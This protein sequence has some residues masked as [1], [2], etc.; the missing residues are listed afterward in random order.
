[1]DFSPEP[2]TL[3]RELLF[4]I[5]SRLPPKILCQLR[6]VCAKWLHLLT[7]DPEF[8]ALYHQKHNLNP[9]LL[10]TDI[11]TAGASSINLSCYYYV[12]GA[13]QSH[14]A[15]GFGG[16]L[17]SILTCRGIAC[18]IRT[19]KIILY[20]P[21]IYRSATVRCCSDSGSTIS[22]AFGY[23]PLSRAFKIV[24]FYE[25]ER[26]DR[27]HYCPVKDVI[28]E[29]QVQPSAKIWSSSR[30]S[31]A[32]WRSLG[33]CQF[34]FDIL[35]R[36]PSVSVDRYV[37]WLIGERRFNPDCIRILSF[38]LEMESFGIV[39]FPRFYSNRSVECVGLL[40]MGERLCL[41]D[42]LPWESTMD[43]WMLQ[44]GGGN[45]WRKE[46]SINLA[47]IDLHDFRIIGHVACREGDEGEILIK[48]G[49]LG[50]VFYVVRKCSFRR[51]KIAMEDG[52]DLQLI[53]KRKAGSTAEDEAL[54]AI[55]GKE[56]AGGGDREEWSQGAIP[57]VDLSTPSSWVELPGFFTETGPSIIKLWE[58]PA[59]SYR[60]GRPI[61]S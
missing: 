60:M 61:Q 3:P 51:L 10:F 6:C 43:I 31:R 46:H 37:Y 56:K 5:F 28:C 9:L 40:E 7:S 44:D 59:H 11:T 18:L 17:I 13:L 53:L 39:C 15:A 19:S 35:S 29:V 20:D 55:H 26:F 54:G 47:G 42:R 30:C 49:A 14:F 24:R 41:T 27:H 25:T 38:D 2:N 45:Q 22:F 50:Y 23:A 33:I 1:M 34:D 4:D 12:D 8:V 48:L 16:D 32:E 36:K 57:V 58:G 52:Q 21:V